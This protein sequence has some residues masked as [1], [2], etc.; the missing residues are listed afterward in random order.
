[1]PWNVLQ[2]ALECPLVCAGLSKVKTDDFRNVVVS[3]S[4]HSGHCYSLILMSEDTKEKKNR[5]KERKGKE[6]KGK[7]RQ[8][9][10]ERPKGSRA[11]GKRMEKSWDDYCD[12]RKVLPSMRQRKT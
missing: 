12:M 9:K 6:R 4:K 8:L 10:K 11:L 7:E 1:M 3:N 5:K 2:N